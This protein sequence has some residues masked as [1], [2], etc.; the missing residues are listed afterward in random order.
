[1]WRVIRSIFVLFLLGF[2]TVASAQLPPK[3]ETEG[4]F[5]NEVIKTQGTCEGLP[6]G[7]ECWMELTNH[8]E[9]YVW[10]G[11]LH[12]GETATWTGQCSG[13][14]PEGKGTLTWENVYK[15]KRKN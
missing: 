10:N 2:F 15:K 7:S 1:M 4:D 9:C 5:Y 12:P 14:L 6:N 3:I 11:Y 8:P 13:Y